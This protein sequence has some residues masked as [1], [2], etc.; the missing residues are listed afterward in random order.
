MVIP[1]LDGS[2][3]TRSASASGSAASST[4]PSEV[5]IAGN[6]VPMVTASVTIFGTATRAT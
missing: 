4:L 3:S 5:C 6:L 2:A 1:D